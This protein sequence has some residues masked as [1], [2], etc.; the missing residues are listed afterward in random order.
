MQVD[1][2]PEKCDCRHTYSHQ[3]PS[4]VNRGELLQATQMPIAGILNKNQLSLVH[5]YF[6]FVRM[7]MNRLMIQQNQI[8]PYFASPVRY[9]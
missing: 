3:M 2:L 7:Y 1:K 9:H 4:Q 5:R 8:F 6:R